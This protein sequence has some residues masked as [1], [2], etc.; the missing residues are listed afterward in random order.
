[1]KDTEQETQVFLDEIQYLKAE[2]RDKD[3]EV[4]S[5]E[6][7][8]EKLLIKNEDLKEENSTL[9][10]RLEKAAIIPENLRDEMKL[11][12]IK[13]HFDRFTQEEFETFFK[14]KTR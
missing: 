1:M 11:E 6:A 7:R 14:S 13:E 5:G 9:K 4:R 2:I 3:S 10:S 8:V 12:C